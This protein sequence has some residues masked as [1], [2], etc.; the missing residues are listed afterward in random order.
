LSFQVRVLDPMSRASPKHRFLIPS[1][2]HTHGRRARLKARTAERR[3]FIL[4]ASYLVTVLIDSLEL[5][6]TRISID[7]AAFKPALGGQ[8]G[9]YFELAR[10]GPG[11]PRA[12]EQHLQL[13]A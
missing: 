6:T 7:S 4:A 8:M 9:R 13:E 10:G 5:P 11:G 1:V 2:G 3:F 12:D